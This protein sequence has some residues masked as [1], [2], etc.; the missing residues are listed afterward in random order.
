[1]VEHDFILSFSDSGAV[2][3]GSVK[4][5]AATVAKGLVA[6]YDGDSGGTLGKWPY[7]PYYWWESGAA[8]GA[9]I[10]YWY[11]TGD[12]TYNDIT[13]T[14]LAA[15]ISSTNDFMPKAETFNLGND[16][17]AFWAIAAMSAAEK[18]FPAPPSPYPGW[19]TIVE[20]VF[21]DWV[22]RWATESCNGG[23]KWQI[24]SENSGYDY[25]NSISNGGFFQ[26]AAR[27]AQATHNQTY[28]D[29]ANK[30][31]DWT[32]SV[33]LIDDSYNVYDGTDDTDNCTSLN[34]LQWT[35]NVG[36]WLYGAAVLQNYTNGAE[37][38][39]DRT[40]GLLDSTSLFTSPFS[41]A[42]DVLYETACE[43]LGNCNTDQLSIDGCARQ[44]HFECKY[45]SFNN[46]IH[47][48]DHNVVT[49]V[50]PEFDIV[51]Y[52]KCD[53]HKLNFICTDINTHV[54]NHASRFL[55]IDAINSDIYLNLGISNH[56]RSAVY[57]IGGPNSRHT[58][59]SS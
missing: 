6:L 31:W 30:I 2:D 14:G 9:L 59:D 15:Q 8:W 1:M 53:D 12:D 26:I 3:A 47:L 38:W 16:D 45:N 33:G 58:F 49:V 10:N 7:P 43:K 32:T 19:L 44:F 55:I 11:Y 18:G 56:K 20:N 4:A 25:K 35:Y 27:L 36:M 41:N 52:N 22:G 17:Q 46:I 23:L 28:V 50:T 51:L 57:W 13:R 42:T 40:T 5:A 48:F 39:A 54:I 34:H 21:N 24:F 37:T 29:W